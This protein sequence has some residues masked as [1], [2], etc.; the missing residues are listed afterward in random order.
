MA[1]LYLVQHGE[2]LAKEIDPDRPLSERGIRDMRRMALMLRRGGVGVE[3][4]LHSDKRR[5]QQTAELLAA[6]IMRGGQPEKVPGIHP[7]DEVATFATQLDNLPQDTL[8]VGHLPFMAR[9]VARLVSGDGDLQMVTFQ[10]G[11]IVCLERQGEGWSLA[12]MVRPT[13]LGED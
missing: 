13:L 5:A 1:K 2:A 7:N 10:P 11:S 3:C 12:W 9:L 6:E 4:V 8:I